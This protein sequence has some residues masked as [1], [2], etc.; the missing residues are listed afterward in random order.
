MRRSLPKLRHVLS[1]ALLAAMASPAACGGSVGTDTPTDGGT[2]SSGSDTSGSDT[3]L[4]D[5][6]G[7]DT[8]VVPDT[9]SCPPT[10]SG[11]ACSET[12]TYP[13]GLPITLATPGAPTTDECKVLCLPADAGVGTF[14]SCWLSSPTS[15]PSQ[16]VNCT[17]CAVGRKPADLRDETPCDVADADVVAG[18]LAEMARIE[19]ASVHAFRRLGGA[20]VRMG[21]PSSLRARVRSAARDEIRHARIVS[22]LARARGGRIRRVTLDR[23]A[24]SPSTFDLALEN[25]VEGCVRET[26][27]VAY[28]AHQRAHAEDASLRAMADELYEEELAHAALSWD[29]IEVLEGSLDDAQRAQLRQAQER[30][31][32][33]VVDEAARMNETVRRAF[34]LPTGR[35]VSRLVR[36]LRGT[37]FAA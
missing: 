23:S 21:A 34:G 14:V 10:V 5:T 26:L 4:T 31:L 12:V 33:E 27:G 37:L 18:A 13:C 19:A 30:A 32:T 35:T 3:A 36:H 6:L 28:L 22:R 11:A 7:R 9:A 24:P 29:L 25:A 20:L 17:S 16:T 1:T 15:G 8:I 2:D